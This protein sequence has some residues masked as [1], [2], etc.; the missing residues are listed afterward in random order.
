[1]VLFIFLKCIG[2]HLKEVVFPKW[3]MNT[4][5]SQMSFFPPYREHHSTANVFADMYKSTGTFI[6]IP[7]YKQYVNSEF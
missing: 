1:M 3:I 2:V 6:K 4:K 5:K 7:C